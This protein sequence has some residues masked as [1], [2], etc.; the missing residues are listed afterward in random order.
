MTSIF[1]SPAYLKERKYLED[2]TK[3]VN[4]RERTK[5]WAI[6]EHGVVLANQSIVVGRI[7]HSD[8][9]RDTDLHRL[10][11]QRVSLK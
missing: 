2:C 10:S 4:I 6:S 3:N 5:G 11:N 1:Q 9:T 8:W 7:E